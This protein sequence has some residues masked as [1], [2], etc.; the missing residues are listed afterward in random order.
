MTRSELRKHWC[1]KYFGDNNLTIEVASEDASFRSYHRITHHT[2][3]TY[4]LMDAPPKQEDIASFIHIQNL[5]LNAGLPVPKIYNSDIELGFI[6]LEDFGNQLY[7]DFLEP[8][9]VDDLYHCAIQHIHK[10]QRINTSSLPNYTAQLLQAELQL[11]IDWFINHHL[12]QKL[13]TNTKNDF[14]QLFDTLIKN[15]LEQP[16]HFVHRDYHSRNLMII[17]NNSP[18]IID[19]QDALLGP[20]TYDLISLTRD[21]YIQWPTEKVQQWSNQFLLDYNKYYDKN[22]SLK[23]WQYWTDLMSIQRH[24]KAIGIFCR[25]NYRDNK[26]QFLKDISRTLKYVMET[27]QSHQ[28]TMKLV[29]ILEKILPSIQSL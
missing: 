13:S 24:L 12:D 16:Q 4:V 10:I 3:N 9:N 6:L 2:Q 15:A 26:P 1:E 22:I 21:C 5:M 27:A 23:Q 29:E 18:G 17:K 19:F 25:L 14:D 8:S 7:L 11:F 20:V 28:Q